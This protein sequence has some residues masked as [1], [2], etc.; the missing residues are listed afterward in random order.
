MS[1]SSRVYP[2]YVTAKTHISLLDRIIKYLCPKKV[3][4]GVFVILW[5]LVLWVSSQVPFDTWDMQ[6][7]LIVALP[8]FSIFL[9]F[10]VHICC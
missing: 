8:R 5:C 6:R 10:A 9:F 7:N 4:I 3:V 1:A 2:I